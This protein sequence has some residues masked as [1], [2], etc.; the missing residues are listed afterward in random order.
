MNPIE[1]SG[2]SQGVT[3]SRIVVDLARAKGG[4]EVDRLAR[5]LLHLV[6][7]GFNGPGILYNAKSLNWA[8]KTD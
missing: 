3:K 4:G 8:R 1:K 6:R 5:N 2:I 7:P